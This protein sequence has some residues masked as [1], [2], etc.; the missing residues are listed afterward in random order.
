MSSVNPVR[1]SA[2]RLI[3]QVLL[4]DDSLKHIY[5]VAINK[6][7]ERKF[8]RHVRGFLGQYAGDLERESTSHGEFQTSTFLGRYPGRIADEIR[9]AIA[10]FDEY[11]RQQAGGSD[12]AVLEKYL[13]DT[14]PR[15]PARD[16]RKVEGVEDEAE[17][18]EPEPPLQ[19]VQL[20]ATVGELEQFLLEGPP[21]RALVQQMQSWLGLRD[22]DLPAGPGPEKE[23]AHD[24]ESTEKD[25]ND[26]KDSNETTSEDTGPLLDSLVT[27]EDTGET[28]Q[29]GVDTGPLPIDHD[30]PDTASLVAGDYFSTE[31]NTSGWRS[32]TLQAVIS[33]LKYYLYDLLSLF[34]P[35]APKGH[36]RLRWK[37]GLAS[38]SSLTNKKRYFEVCV[39]AANHEIHHREI[40]I[41]LARSDGELFE[42]IWDTYNSCRGFGLRRFFLK[43]RDIHFVMFSINPLYTY[44]AGIHKKPN[45]YPP[46]DELQEKRYHYACPKISMPANIFLHFLHRARM[47][48]LEEHHDD[49][50]LDHLPK[51]LDSKVAAALR[52]A[53]ALQPGVGDRLVFGWGVHILEGPNHSALGFLLTLGI[54]VTKPCLGRVTSDVKA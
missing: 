17:D 40:D 47:N 6:T 42:M 52:G 2:I 8:R 25:E 29:H 39:N 24:T 38:N 28:D 44:S 20:S 26:N 31:T 36:R 33:P 46:E 3:T 49:I 12:R 14:A 51:K 22:N 9:W 48:S 10:G 23:Q 15:G 54:V 43:P 1:T 30:I 16:P 18:D 37:C 32:E 7:D 45:E 11:S 35:P 19:D 34:Q 21:F 41:T 27:R 53:R 4:S 5:D 50:W 13:S